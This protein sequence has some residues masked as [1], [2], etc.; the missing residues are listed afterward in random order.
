MAFENEYSFQ[1]R[2]RKGGS[3]RKES[4]DF[5]VG[6]EE[7]EKKVRESNFVL[8]SILRVFMQLMQPICKCY[9]EMKNI[10][11]NHKEKKCK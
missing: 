11:K 9:C 8:L 1:A 2:Y 3:R 6:E 5:K 7:N 10:K 4:G